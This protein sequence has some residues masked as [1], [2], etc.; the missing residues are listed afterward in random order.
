MMQAF[1]PMLLMQSQM[2]GVIGLYYYY[3]VI[4]KI[5]QSNK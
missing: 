5:K 3:F 1:K 4:I 2:K